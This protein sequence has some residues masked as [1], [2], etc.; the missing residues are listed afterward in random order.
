[1]KQDLSDDIET[2]AAILRLDYAKL[3]RQFS[4]NLQTQLRLNSS[5][6]GFLKLWIPDEDIGRSLNSLLEAAALSSIESIDL[7][8]TQERL[9]GVDLESLQQR[10][11]HF[12]QVSVSTSSYQIVIAV[13]ENRVADSGQPIKDEIRETKVADID[14][15]YGGGAKETPAHYLKVLEDWGQSATNKATIPSN[16]AEGCEVFQ[17]PVGE[18]LFF[19]IINLVSGEITDAGTVGV[20]DVALRGALGRLATT[21][22]RLPM[23][24]AAEHGVLYVLQDL[25]NVSSAPTSH[26][27]GILLPFNAGS[28]IFA[29]LEVCQKFFGFL[30]Q[31]L[32]DGMPT[33]GSEYEGVPDQVWQSLEK[34]DKVLKIRDIISDFADAKGISNDAFEMNALNP[35]LSGRD[36]RVFVTFGSDIDIPSRP[37]VIRAL[38]IQLKEQ[39]SKLLTVFYAP[40]VDKNKIR[41]L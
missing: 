5:D 10:L 34:L 15:E 36:V 32:K 24:E 30:Q 19:A 7:L 9:A 17:A 4:D 26:I 38:E 3:E 29:A 6:S 28:Q 21:I 13:R 18:G 41:R 39:A 23:V 2:E 37:D 8:F 33:Y 14:Y 12:A 20:D 1:M 25:D 40:E 11:A 16:A 22:M 27:S 35:D 31:H